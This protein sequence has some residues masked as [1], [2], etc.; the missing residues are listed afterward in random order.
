MRKY[1]NAALFIPI[2]IFGCFNNSFTTRNQQDA[3]IQDQNNGNIDPRSE[4][5]LNLYGNTIKYY[6]NKYGIDWR[7][8]IALMKVESQFD[9]RAES[10][11]GAEGLMQIIPTTQLQIA[12]EIGVD[13]SLFNDPR[14]NIQGGIYYL[15]KAYNAFESQKLSE[16]NRLKFALAA[17]NAGL[18]RV[19]DAQAMAEY[20]NDNPKEWQSIKN[21]LSLL[22]KRYS[23]IHKYV[24]EDQKPSSG[25]FRDWQQ[26]SN[27]VESVM[28]YYRDYKRIYSHQS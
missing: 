27:Y 1:I 24:W 9:H 2:A 6:S 25:Y 26:T 28:G 12:E 5:V 7:L 19:L 23:Y 3:L 18:G 4:K 13:T 21:S 22:S 11:K 17:Y 14:I 15:S 20:V 10:H 8:V 16:E